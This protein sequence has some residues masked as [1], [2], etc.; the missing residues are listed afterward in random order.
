MRFNQAGT[1]I[2]ISVGLFCRLVV[3]VECRWEVVT[4]LLVVIVDY[5]DVDCDYYWY[6]VN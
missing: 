3:L 6:Y 4:L 2:F 5:C 1:I